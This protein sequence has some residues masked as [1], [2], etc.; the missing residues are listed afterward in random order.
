MSF[1]E[2]PECLIKICCRNVFF[3]CDCSPS[4]LPL[5]GAVVERCKFR[6]CMGIAL[7]INNNFIRERMKVGYCLHCLFFFIRFLDAFL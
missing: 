5:Y 2:P 7:P 4:G 1:G 6:N 3:L